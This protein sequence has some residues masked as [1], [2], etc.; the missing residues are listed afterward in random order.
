MSYFEYLK[1][2]YYHAQ[3][4]MPG[5]YTRHDLA[6]H[7]LKT[8]SHGSPEFSSFDQAMAWKQFFE[9]IVYGDK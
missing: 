4:K 9:W 6:M 1:Q 5:A 3:Q 8:E 2:C 7:V